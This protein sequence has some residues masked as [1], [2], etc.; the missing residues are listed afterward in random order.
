[1]TWSFYSEAYEGKGTQIVRISSNRAE[2]RTIIRLGPKAGRLLIDVIDADSKQRVKDASVAMNHKGRPKTLIRSGSNTP[3][4]FD[5][6]I[7]PDVSVEIA[8]GAPGYQTYHYQKNDQDFLKLSSG[9]E[10]T[11][12]IELHH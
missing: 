8:I 3:D 12:T 11:L 2:T 1:M 10:K 7:P 5:L 9:A 6:L 4:G